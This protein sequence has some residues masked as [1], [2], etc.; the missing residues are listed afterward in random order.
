IVL[1]V[2]ALT[3][4][5]LVLSGNALSN[6][7][8]SVPSIV[9]MLALFAVPASEGALAFFNTVVSLFLKPTRL[10]GYDYR[11]GVPPEARTLVV[12][13]SLIGSRDDVE[14]NIRNIEVHHLA[15]TAEEIH[16]ALL[17][18]W[19]DSKTEIDAADIEILQ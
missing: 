9:L 7:G 1:P 18:D 12:V 2:F 17:S 5:L 15:N 8:L 4:L 6:L 19:P 3:A 16:F 13:P 14:E 11:H 10:I